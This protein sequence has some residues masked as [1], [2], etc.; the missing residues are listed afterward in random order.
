MRRGNQH[1]EDF[2]PVLNRDTA[3]PE[4]TELMSH[5]N[6]CQHCREE[7][8]GWQSLDDLFRSEQANLEVP[9]FQWGRIAA[10]LEETRGAGVPSGLRSWFLPRQAAWNVALGAA[11]LA[12]VIFGGLEYS[13]NIQEKQ[14]LLAV[15][16]YAQEE[17]IRISADGNPFR[18]GTAAE[19][20]PFTGIMGIDNSKPAADRR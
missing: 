17:G 16:R 18:S 11:V 12:A 6:Q 9:P 5:L 15:T 7:L 1:P 2:G 10:R 19:N 8:K 13:R 4:F 20:N 14:V 3:D